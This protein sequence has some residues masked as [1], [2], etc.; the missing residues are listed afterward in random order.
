M[1]YLR[2][3]PLQDLSDPYYAISDADADPTEKWLFADATLAAG[4]T[5]TGGTDWKLSTC[6]GTDEIIFL[7]LMAGYLVIIYFLW[8]N[9]IMKPMKLIAVFVHEMG[10]ATACW[11]TCGKVKA[12]EVYGNE[13]GV[14]KYVGGWRW[15][16]IPAG[17]VGGAFWGA[18]FVVLSGDRWAS[19]AAAII[20]CL[21]MTVSLFFSPNRTMVLL[22]LGFILLT[23]GFILMDQL[24][25]TPFLQYLTLFY[26][27]FIGSFSVYDIY[28][29]LITRTVE[30][31]DAHACHKLI[32][33]CLPRCVGVQ[34]AVL[35][36]A[37][38]ALGLYFALVWMT[39]T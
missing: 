26:G 22:N 11:M 39:S 27:V 20:F 24:V 19:L 34:F 6:C 2:Q 25:I 30:G 29:D 1:V 31:S 7:C 10:H 21:G 18:F 8:N 37:F 4:E 3:D 9:I 36:I 15:F 38:Q 17:Y 23:V 33:C 13:G 32:P 5:S 14:T 12:I 16:I 35:A 28:D